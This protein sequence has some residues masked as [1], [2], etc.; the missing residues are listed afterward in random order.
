[1]PREGYPR[2]PPGREAVGLYGPRHCHAPEHQARSWSMLAAHSPTA[3]C[4]TGAAGRSGPHPQGCWRLRGQ[5]G[6]RDE[7]AAGQ[8][9]LPRLL[10]RQGEPRGGHLPGGAGSLEGPS[11]E[12]RKLEENKWLD[13]EP[14][15][16]Q[17]Q[18]S[19]SPWPRRRLVPA[20]RH[21]RPRP[22][23][24]LELAT[25]ARAVAGMARALSLAHPCLPRSPLAVPAASPQ[26]PAAEPRTGP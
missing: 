3:T 21:Q 8:K 15:E 25:V 22:G 12:E 17:L 2:Q 23:A 18:P 6:P 4:P 24:P 16:P 13:Q 9:E 5:R 11:V 20:S 10:G 7:A 1:M 14:G 19:H 26:P